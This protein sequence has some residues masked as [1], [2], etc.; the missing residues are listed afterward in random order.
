[1]QRK[2]SGIGDKLKHHTPLG[3]KWLTIGLGVVTLLWLRVEDITPNYVIGL[4]AAWCAWAG[5]RFVLQWDRELQAGPY[6]VG[7]FVA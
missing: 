6:I 7:G 4:G 1:M 3:L 2:N 5:M